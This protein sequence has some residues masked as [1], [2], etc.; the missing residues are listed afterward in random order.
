MS[1]REVTPIDGQDL[2]APRPQ[3][4]HRAPL[5]ADE[6]F[7]LAPPRQEQ[8]QGS[9][10]SDDSSDVEVVERIPEDDLDAPG[11]P[12][13]SPPESPTLA[14]IREHVDRG[15]YLA[16]FTLL[17]LLI[18]AQALP[19]YEAQVEALVGEIHRRRGESYGRAGTLD[20]EPMEDVDF[21]N[22]P[23]AADVQRYDGRLACYCRWPPQTRP[24]HSHAR[25]SRC[26][27]LPSHRQG[28]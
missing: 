27:H 14:W 22:S 19:T 24:Y 20:P 18:A 6:S 5:R 1:R 13:G 3:R 8:V 16:L 11:T 9:M 2:N 4:R 25:F 23:P 28:Q 10:D 15:S 17:L 26:H 12:P 7:T 21:S